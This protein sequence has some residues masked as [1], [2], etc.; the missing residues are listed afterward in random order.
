M[1]EKVAKKIVENR[2][3]TDLRMEFLLW[4]IVERIF[5]KEIDEIVEFFGRNKML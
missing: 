5:G 2:S 4:F 3:L 1:K